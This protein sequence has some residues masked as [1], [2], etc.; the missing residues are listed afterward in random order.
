MQI[1]SSKKTLK[2]PDKLEIAQYHKPRLLKYAQ[3]L[4]WGFI[5]RLTKK[6]WRKKGTLSLIFIYARELFSSISFL[7]SARL[8][9]RAIFFKSKIFS[10]SRVTR[11]FFCPYCTRECSIGES[12]HGVFL[13]L[14]PSYIYAS[15]MTAYVYFVFSGISFC[16]TAPH[17]RVILVWST[18][19][20]Y[21]SMNN[22]HLFAEVKNFRNI[23]R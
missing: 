18:G 5:F 1:L 21:M 23:L 15:S 20:V 12:G 2:N 6:K 14:L 17:A 13:P 16:T 10:S 7:L 8:F 11:Y 9:D 4:L 22:I 3:K 19:V